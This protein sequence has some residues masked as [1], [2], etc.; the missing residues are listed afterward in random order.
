MSSY[1]STNYYNKPGVNPNYNPYPK[2]IYIHDNRLKG[3]GDSPDGLKLKT[4]KLAMFGLNGRLPDVLWDGY[5][6]PKDVGPDGLPP[7]EDRI[8]VPN[9]KV[10]VLDADGP[11]DYK[12]PNTD[13]KRFRCDLKPLPPVHLDLAAADAQAGA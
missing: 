13:D 12:N 8:C 11:H 7:V 4:L 5:Y 2:A 9:P 10:V 6:D 3:G 1:F